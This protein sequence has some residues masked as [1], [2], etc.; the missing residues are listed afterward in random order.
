MIFPICFHR[1]LNLSCEFILTPCSDKS[2]QVQD[3]IAICPAVASQKVAMAA[4]ESGRQWV[5]GNSAGVSPR[6]RMEMWCLCLGVG[7][8]KHHPEEIVTYCN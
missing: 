8:S 4:L 6:L 5:W 7:I 1:F 2:A 3:T